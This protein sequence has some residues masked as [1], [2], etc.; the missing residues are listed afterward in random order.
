MAVDTLLNAL[1][2]EGRITVGAA[3]G[4]RA[5]AVTHDGRLLDDF[6]F[7]ETDRTV[8]VVNAPSP[9]ATASL[10]IAAEVVARVDA[11]PGLG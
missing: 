8:H 11:R 10:A 4:I 7:R 3:A 9:A 6:A 5:Q 2:R 1:V